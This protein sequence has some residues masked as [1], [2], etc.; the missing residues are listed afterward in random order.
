ML[1]PALI[2]KNLFQTKREETKP[3]EEKPAKPKRGGYHIIRYNSA[4]KSIIHI[5]LAKG[6]TRKEIKVILEKI[7]VTE[8]PSY[9]GLLPKEEWCDAF[10]SYLAVLGLDI[11][12]KEEGAGL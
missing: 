5:L 4:I 11:V 10:K 9:N 2:I 6:A 1:D 3:Q 7:G 8:F 12:R